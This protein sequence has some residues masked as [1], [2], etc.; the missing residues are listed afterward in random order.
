[1]INI[2]IVKYSSKPEQI[3][4]L[5]TIINLNLLLLLNLLNNDIKI[6]KNLRQQ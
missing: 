3:Q 1:M 5:N 6:D 2:L 4:T